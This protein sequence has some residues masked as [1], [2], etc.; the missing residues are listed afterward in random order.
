MRSCWCARTARCR[1]A[2]LGS[3]TAR[4][5]MQRGGGLV[6]GRCRRSATWSSWSRPSGRWRGSSP[7]RRRRRPTTSC[8]LC[9]CWTCGWRW[10]RT[11]WSSTRTAWPPPFP[12]L[13][14]RLTTCGSC[15][16]AS[17]ARRARRRW[18]ASRARC[19][20]S[21]ASAFSSGPAT[22]SLGATGRLLAARCPRPR[23]GT[24][25]SRRRT[26]AAASPRTGPPATVPRTPDGGRARRC[27]SG[28]GR[29]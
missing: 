11:R 1:A 13:R 29:R 9:C 2:A 23:S 21:A 5:R 3:T 15:R 16:T 7:R 19:G 25:R 6:R 22:A 12:T 17:T 26:Q 14:L 10:W 8:C 18:R 4:H 24:R 20:W 27:S 28:R